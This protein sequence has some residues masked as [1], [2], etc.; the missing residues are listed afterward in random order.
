M[1]GAAVCAMGQGA[2]D[3]QLLGIATFV[4]GV[5]MTGAQMSMLALAA[6]FYPT[7]GRASGVAWMLGIGRLGGI[8][9]AL[10]GGALSAAGFSMITIL[11]SMAAPAVI[12]AMALLVAVSASKKQ[13]N[14]PAAIVDSRLGGSAIAERRTATRSGHPVT[15]SNIF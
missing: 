8:L 1:L 14:L 7:H 12:A 4:A 5:C 10:G 15:S 2:V 11:T 13:R 9:G 6:L 3:V